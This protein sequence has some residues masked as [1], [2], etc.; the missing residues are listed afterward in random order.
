M[1]EL[2]RSDTWERE[3]TGS[4][5]LDKGTKTRLLAGITFVQMVDLN[6]IHSLYTVRL[7]LPQL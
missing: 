5:F 6:P 1:A 2:S 7:S 3:A 4:S